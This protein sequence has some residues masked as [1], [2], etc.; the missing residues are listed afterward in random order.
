MTATP[1][2][3]FRAL[4]FEAFADAIRRR[5]VPV[6]AVISLL[7]L[8]AVDSCTSCASGELNVNGQVADLASVAGWTGA[9]IFSMLALWTMVLAGVIASDHL[10]HPLADGSAALA[11]ARPVSRST[12]ALSRLAGALG[13]AGLTGALLLGG[14][15][16][17]LAARSGATPGAALW[18]GVACAAGSFTVACLSMTS[19]LWL[20]QIATALLVFASVAAISSVNLLSQFGVEL[21]GAMAAVERFGPPLATSVVVAL[22]PWVEPAEVLGHPVE[23]AI[24]SALWCLGSAALLLA[25]FQRLE[26]GR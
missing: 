22:G 10:S 14:T 21:G 8:L 13:I 23:L 11:L 16:A 15:T 2:G 6:I 24:R 3:A 5:I 26:I 1:S 20:P 4:T 17:L 7:S 25:S 12:F 18:A 9:M 19:S